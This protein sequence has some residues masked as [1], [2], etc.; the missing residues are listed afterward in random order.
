L[1]L[2]QPQVA[3]SDWYQ[4]PGYPYLQ[5]IAKILD[6]VVNLPYIQ[7]SFPVSQLPSSICDHLE[8]QQIYSFAK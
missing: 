6:D 8:T 5:A 3:D 4:Q 2:D 7:Q 1:G